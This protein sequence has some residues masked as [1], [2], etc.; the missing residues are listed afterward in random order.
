V[1]LKSSEV[2]GNTASCSTSD[3]LARGGGLDNCCNGTL[4]VDNSRVADNTVSTPL[5][6]ALGGG[7][8]SDSGTSTLTSSAV[9]GNQ[10]SGATA[11]GGGI[12]KEGGSVILNDT[13]CPATRPITASLQSTP[14]PELVQ[15]SPQLLPAPTHEFDLQNPVGF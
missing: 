15:R 7:V 9:T 3:C 4:N 13:G 8:M 1:N 14:V 5:G 10:A 11:E 6:T 12:Y 2:A